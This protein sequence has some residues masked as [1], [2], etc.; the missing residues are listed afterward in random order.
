MSSSS[1]AATSPRRTGRASAVPSS[2]ISAYADTWS[3]LQASAASRLVSQSAERLPR[4]AVD[5]VE[6]DLVE[7]RGPRPGHRLRHPLRVVGAVQRGQ[8]VRHGRLHAERHPGEARP[9]A[10][11]RARPG[12]RCPGWPRWSPRRPRPARTRRRRRRSRPARSSAGEQGRRTA[13]DEDRRHRRRGV[14][15]HPPGQPDL[16]RGDP[17]VRRL[18]HGRGGPAE[19][20]R[21]V[22]V[23]VAVA[24]PDRSRTA[25]AGTAPNGSRAERRP[26][27]PPGATPSAGTGSPGGRADG[28]R[29]SNQRPVVDVRGRPRPSLETPRTQRRPQPGHRVSRPSATADAPR[30]SHLNQRR[31]RAPRT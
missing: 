28:T 2:T 9:P 3:G 30:S 19:L 5:Q 17:G 23:E 16:V 22:G 18:G 8:H 13:A 15:E 6:A 27:P 26:A 24:A 29:P 12:R 7:A 10:A 21:G 25:R 4:R 14:A 20:E 11:G 1:G 31:A